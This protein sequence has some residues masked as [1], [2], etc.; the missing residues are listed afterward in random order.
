MSTCR[1]TPTL[2][3]MAPLTQKP[4]R[5]PPETPPLGGTL[6]P[7]QRCIPLRRTFALGGSSELQASTQAAGLSLSLPFPELFALGDRSPVVP[8]SA[9]V[10]PNT[11]WVG[12]VHL[13]EGSS[14]FYGAELRADNEPI[15][16]GL[17]SNVQ[18]NCDFHIDTGKPVTLGEGVSV[19]PP[20]RS[21][22]VSRSATMCWS[23]WAP[24]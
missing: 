5:S 9:W 2:P 3:P 23:G 1:Y 15:T 11:T 4:R 8:Q 16:I 21:S 6:T 17:R 18:D 13:A 10:T 22:T 12:S 20:A 24:L 19:G 14:V 7:K